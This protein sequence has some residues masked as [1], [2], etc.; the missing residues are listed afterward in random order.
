M[1]KAFFQ[2]LLIIFNLK[3]IALFFFQNWLFRLFISKG[4]SPFI[5]QKGTKI[6]QMEIESINLKF[7]NTSCFISGDEYDVAKMYRLSFD[8]HYFP[9][10]IP[11]P[12][13]IFCN[14]EGDIPDLENFLDFQDTLN[15]KMEKQ[16]FINQFAKKK[17]WNYQKELLIFVNQK[18]FLFIHLSMIVLTFKKISN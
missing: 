3:L 4:I 8:R 9:L 13:E 1:I 11:L 17:K 10:N 15:I 2:D 7:I 12:F 5:I 16:N 18:A 14:Y 6:Y